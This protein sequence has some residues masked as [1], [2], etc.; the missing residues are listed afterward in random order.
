MRLEVLVAT[1]FQQ[2]QSLISTMNIQSDAIIV[3]QCDKNEIIDFKIGKRKIKLI[4]LKERGVGLSRNN[5][6]MRS[7][8]DVV[9]FSD[10]DVVFANGYEDLILKEFNNPKVDMCF[11]NIRCTTPGKSN[12]VIQEHKRVYRYKALHYG[13]VRIAA[14]LESIRRANVYFSLL[15][16]GGARY[17]AGEDSLFIWECLQ[18]GLKAYCSPEFIGSVSHEKSSWFNGYTDKYFFDK[19]VLFVHLSR[20]FASLLCLQFAIRHRKMFKN[21]KSWLMAYKAMI[22]GVKSV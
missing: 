2:D 15:F 7:S 9:L 10:E 19:G 20:R 6:L 4:S 1:M 18:K 17:S 14:R 22:S 13:A 16:G 3:N 11:F 21:E 12:R 8:A 5:A